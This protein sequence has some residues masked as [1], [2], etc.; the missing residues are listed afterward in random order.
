MNKREENESP[1]SL[2]M[3]CNEVKRREMEAKMPK[4]PSCPMNNETNNTIGK[5][6]R[7]PLPGSENQASKG[8]LAIKVQRQLKGEFQHLPR[9]MPL[10]HPPALYQ[11]LSFFFSEALKFYIVNALPFLSF[12][13]NHMEA[14]SSSPSQSCLNSGTG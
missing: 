14:D 6:L 9:D 7:P 10:R 5:K 1:S 3:Q 2:A 8:G 13:F 4:D 12:S 11:H